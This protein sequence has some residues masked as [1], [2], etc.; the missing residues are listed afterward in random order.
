MKCSIK[1]TRKFWPKNYDIIL[2]NLFS[3]VIVIK[4]QCI[5]KQIVTELLHV[6]L[7]QSRWWNWF[8]LEDDKNETEKLWNDEYSVHAV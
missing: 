8:M 6:G 4:S 2:M 5:K 3:H 1:T 7:D